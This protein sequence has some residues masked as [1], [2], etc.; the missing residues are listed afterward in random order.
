MKNFLV[1]FLIVMIISGCFAPL[2]EEEETPNV[3]GSWKYNYETLGDDVVTIA[4]LQNNAMEGRVNDNQWISA[5]LS[6]GKAL[7]RFPIAHFLT[8]ANTVSVRSKAGDK[9]GSITSKTLYKGSYAFDDT[10]T[11]SFDVTVKTGGSIINDVVVQVRNAKGTVDWDD[12]V[13]VYILPDDTGV[14]AVENMVE[15]AQFWVEADEYI[16]YDTWYEGEFIHTANLI[17]PVA[18]TEVQGTFLIRTSEG[19]VPITEAHGDIAGIGVQYPDGDIGVSVCYLRYYGDHDVAGSYDQ[20][21]GE[22]RVTV[23]GAGTFNS[24]CNILT[25]WGWNYIASGTYYIANGE[26][27]QMDYTVETR[28]GTVSGT[29]TRGGEAVAN[30]N[31]RLYTDITWNG[32]VNRLHS[33]TVAT[34]D[35]GAYTIDVLYG[36]YTLMASGINDNLNDSTDAEITQS[37]TID[38][39]TEVNII[40]P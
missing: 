22:Y 26:T 16:L 9:T 39:A 13:F 17:R 21:T 30:C 10:G 6:G 40:L 12:D 23:L 18:G 28:V 19:E 35:T 20:N 14:V 8:G 2:P 34:D 27:K 33:N 25:P 38:G 32:N 36:T 37:V 31:I 24:F 11:T 3:D 1:L 29:V 7:I 15:S 4:I 5:T